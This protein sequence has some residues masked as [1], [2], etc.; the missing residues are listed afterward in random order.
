MGT[1]RRRSGNLIW[2][3][4]AEYVFLPLKLLESRLVM[5]MANQED[6]VSRRGNGSLIPTP[7]PCRSMPLPIWRE[8]GAG[9]AP[10]PG[11]G[12]CVS[13]SVSAPSER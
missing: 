3:E 8:L 7:F 2:G 10:A 9:G 12:H 4:E 1:S 5:P 11:C 6:G 13:L